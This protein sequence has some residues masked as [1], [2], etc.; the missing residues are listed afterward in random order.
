MLRY[1]LQELA[2]QCS[3]RCVGTTHYSSAALLMSDIYASAAQGPLVVG[4]PS[5]MHFCVNYCSAVKS[6]GLARQPIWSGW[7]AL[8]RN[9][10]ATRPDGCLVSRESYVSPDAAAACCCKLLAAAAASC[11]L[12]AALE[13]LP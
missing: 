2:D 8:P 13:E 12:G 5:A 4:V 7:R 9:T 6:A 10:L 11:A 3:R 1:Q